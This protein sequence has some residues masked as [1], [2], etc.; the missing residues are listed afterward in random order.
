MRVI[1]HDNVV[2][3]CHYVTS[4]SLFTVTWYMRVIIRSQPEHHF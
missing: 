1:I 3:A 4:V 2:H